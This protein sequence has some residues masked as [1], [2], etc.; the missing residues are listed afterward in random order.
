[1]EQIRLLS[2]VTTRQPLTYL[3]QRNLSRGLNV[4]WPPP[5]QDRTGI[6][7]YIVSDEFKGHVQL[8]YAH[9]GDVSKMK[10]TLSSKLANF[11]HPQT[12]DS[13]LVSTPGLVG[14]AIP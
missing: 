10:R 11:Q 14:V 1:M 2:T 9:R 5:T 8:E 4:S 7:L 6:F 12:Q 13:P 3:L